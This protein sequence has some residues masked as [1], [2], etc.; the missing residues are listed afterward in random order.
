MIVME[1]NNDVLN[2]INEKLLEEDEHEEE[3]MHHHSHTQH[4]LK[5]LSHAW[6]I[7]INEV[8]RFASEIKTERDHRIDELKRQIQQNQYS[9]DCE[10]I[11]TTL[12]L[13][14]LAAK[15]R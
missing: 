14:E 7:D 3:L 6:Q 5:G 8:Y 4:C 2:E 1:S 12:I 11:A 10:A 13:G 15:H 9:P